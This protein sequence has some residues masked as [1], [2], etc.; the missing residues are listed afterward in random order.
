VFISNDS[1]FWKEGVDEPK[2]EIKSDITS[3]QGLLRIYKSVEHFLAEN[4]LTTEP[5]SREWALNVFE[6]GDLGRVL[7]ARTLAKHFPEVYPLS[8]EIKS[9]DF[10]KGSLYNISVDSRFAEISYRA[11]VDVEARVTTYTLAP[12]NSPTFI[13]A[14]DS[15][16]ASFVEASTIWN[17]VEENSVWNSYQIPTYA[18]SV[19]SQAAGTNL[20]NPPVPNRLSRPYQPTTR[21]ERIKLTIE[22]KFSLWIQGETL[23]QSQ[24]DALNIENTDVRPLIQNE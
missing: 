8:H 9:V 7:L 13:N 14:I 22:A 2:D 3:T 12:M 11:T 20:V 6:R 17:V 4:V 24:V 21:H 15:G 18:N 23:I 16:A 5:V 19:L 10:V 1:G